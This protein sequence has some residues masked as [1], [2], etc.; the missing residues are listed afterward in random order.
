[1][2]PHAT[3]RREGGLTSCHGCSRKA[4][5]KLLGAPTIGRRSGRAV[6]GGGGSERRQIAP[7]P[8][9]IYKNGAE[10]RRFHYKVLKKYTPKRNTIIL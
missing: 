1:M 5:Q 4:A 8:A 3:N 2:T 7:K 10:N 9:E 6:G